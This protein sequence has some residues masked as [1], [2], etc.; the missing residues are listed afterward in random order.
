MT[1][2]RKKP[3]K[4]RKRQARNVPPYPFKFRIQVAR[5]HVEDGHPASLVAEQFG[6]SEY[7]VYRWSKLYRL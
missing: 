6:I 2:R 7:S 3:L 4:K 1:A 5:L